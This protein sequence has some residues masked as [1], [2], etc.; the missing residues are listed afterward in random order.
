[1]TVSDVAH[2]TILAQCLLFKR[3]YHLI[4]KLNH[5]YLCGILDSISTVLTSTGFTMVKKANPMPV[6]ARYGMS[7][8]TVKCHYDRVQHIMILLKAMK[9]QQQNWNQV[10]NSQQTPHILPWRARYGL[11]VVRIW[12]K[13]NCIVMAQYCIL[14]YIQFGIPVVYAVLYYTNTFYKKYLT[15][16]W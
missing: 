6:R 9:W 1:M 5:N 11:S 10:S 13:I 7:L 4:F 3:W 2:I 15:W 16:W 14:D 8:S 12:E